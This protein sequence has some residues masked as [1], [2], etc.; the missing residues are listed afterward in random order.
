M[1]NRKKIYNII[2]LSLIL[3]LISVFIISYYINEKTV[4]VYQ[5]RNIQSNVSTEKLSIPLEGLGTNKKEA[6]Y[7]EGEAIIAIRPTMSLLSTRFKANSILDELDKEELAVIKNENAVTYNSLRDTPNSDE[8]NISLVKSDKYTTEELIEKLEDEGIYAEPN[9]VLY[10]TGV[11]NDTYL[12]SQWAIEN[13]G[14]NGGTEGVDINPISTTSTEEKVI[15]IIDSGVDYTHEDLKNVMWQ[16]PYSSS[17]DLPGLYGY[18]FGDNDTDP[19]D[20]D[21]HGTHIAGIIAGE[22]NNNKGITGTLLKDANIKIMALKFMNSEGKQYTSAAIKA[23]DYIYKAQQKGVN[24]VAINNSWGSY[25]EAVE[26]GSLLTT[27]IDT[28]GAKGALSICSE[29]N[30]ALNTDEYIHSP[31]GLD[32]D[33]IIS[34]ASSN[35]SD[36]LSNFSNYGS[37]T[38]DIAAPG[39][40]ILSTVP[41]NVFNPS[42]YTDTERNNLCSKFEDFSTIDY[43]NILLTDGDIKQSSTEYFGNKGGKSLEWKIEEADINKTYCLVFPLE[44]ISESQYIS[45]MIKAKAPS[46]GVYIEDFEMTL[47]GIWACYYYSENFE[48]LDYVEYSNIGD[49]YGIGSTLGEDTQW[50]HFYSK[51]KHVGGTILILYNPYVAG[52]HTLYLDNLAISSSTATEEDFWKYEFYDGTSMATPFVTAAVGIASNKYNETDALELKEKVLQAVRPSASLTGK[53]ATGGVLDLSKLPTT[54]V[55]PTLNLSTNQNEVKWSNINT[56]PVQNTVEGKIYQYSLDGG[57]TWLECNNNNIVLSKDGIYQIKVRE[58][59]SENVSNT[60]IY[61]LDTTAPSL[62]VTPNKVTEEVQQVTPEITLSDLSSGIKSTNIEYVYS[63]STTPPQDVTQYQTVNLTNG[64]LNLTS[65]DNATGTY[66]LYIKPIE[67]NATNKSGTQVHKYGPY[68]LKAPIAVEGVTLNKS[69]IIMHQG[70]IDNTLQATINPSDA[71]NK[72]M[73]WSSSD[74]TIVEIN[75]TTGEFIAQKEGCA[76]ITVTTEDQAKTATCE[77]TVIN[78][79]LNLSTEESNSTWIKP[80]DI[81]NI[82]QK[83]ELINTIEGKQYEYTT[84]GGESW[85]LCNYDNITQKWSININTE[86]IHKIKVRLKD[87]TIISNEYIYK[88]DASTPIVEIEG[89]KDNPLYIKAIVIDEYSGLANN[90]IEYVILDREPDEVTEWNRANIDG[91]G[92]A[93]LLLPNVDGTF[94]IYIKPVYDNVGLKSIENGNHLFEGYTFTNTIAVTGISLNKN[95]IKLNLG[96]EEQLLAT[97]E[98]EDATN[99]DIIWNSENSSIAT[100][101]TDGHVTAIGKGTTVITATSLSGGFVAECTINVIVPIEGLTLSKTTE[102]LVVGENTSLQAVITPT[103]AS[104]KS[105]EWSSS[106]EAIATVSQDGTVTAINKGIVE[107]MVSVTDEEDTNLKATSVITIEENASPVIDITNVTLNKETITIHQGKTEKLLATIEPDDATDKDLFW[108]SSDETIATV[109][110][111]GTV[112]AINKGTTTITVSNQDGTVKDTAEVTVI[113]PLLDVTLTETAI[114]EV[115]NTINLIALVNPSDANINSV[116]WVSSDNTIAEVDNNGVVKGLKKG[117]AKIGVRVTD[118]EGTQ[119]TDVCDVT[120]TEKTTIEFVPV[121]EITLGNTSLKL[122]KNTTHKINLIILPQNADIKSIQWKSSNTQVATVDN[123]GIVKALKVGETEIEV[124]VEDKLG[125]IKTATCKLTVGEVEQEDDEQKQ[126]PSQNDKENKQDKEETETTT[127]PAKK[128]DLTTSTQV[129][130]ATGIKGLIIAIVV[131]GTVLIISFLRYRNLR[132][133]K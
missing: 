129:L 121:T 49:V 23:Y 100:V 102:T 54:V 101:S 61:K 77:V 63:T 85:I 33:Y 22:S 106:D 19:I 132:D 67:D 51:T 97:I 17:T 93:N 39:S 80:E 8:I 108:S 31:S 71:T 53:V 95:N 118:V 11:S 105:I 28:V 45:A 59:D 114:V 81:N 91:E 111:D 44:T 69:E 133:V 16:N 60:Y 123:E 56:I 29:G 112:T 68:N 72:D 15:A 88:L 94:N 115:G 90:Y 89:E 5:V 126:E 99:K 34:V 64:K 4:A 124:I 30:D 107:I 36:K 26:D 46:E 10:S 18:D 12:S 24:V 87:S 58:K 84:N 98:P 122:N 55:I 13:I 62:S 57:T 65:P 109:S 117:I 116:E 86:G 42:I 7:A 1:K 9:Y 14:Q 35:V 127:K 128:E 40:N 32:S 104:I 6:K 131:I 2:F 119:K 37:T 76:T 75:S 96:E 120:V 73:T 113:I 79:S 66:Y 52:D 70:E 25:I 21:G 82:N 38:A 130:P 103:D 110:E 3:I 27:V 47:S 78:P 41:Y 48:D 83:I 74:N 20:V 125:N 43:E 50:N 92:K